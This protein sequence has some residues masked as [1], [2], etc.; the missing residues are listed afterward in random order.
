MNGTFIV[1]DGPD[2]SGTTLHTKLLCERLQAEGKEVV[3]TAEPT[4]GPIGTWIREQ[5]KNGVQ[6]PAAAIQLAFTAD[7]AWHVEHVIQPAL[8]A[9]KTVVCDRYSFSTIAYGSA[10]GLDAAWLT[11]MNAL[12]LKPDITIFA[13]PSIDVCM[14]RLSRRSFN[15]SFEKR[16][17]QEKVH[18]AYQS[19]SASDSSITTIDT[20]GEKQETANKIWEI[21]SKNL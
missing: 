21:V 4:D 3:Q 14:E 19:L 9:G 15:D 7:R 16:E 13:L 8:D 2:G 12:F 1:L 11:N 6:I 17:L 10:L 18:A 20:S 5:L